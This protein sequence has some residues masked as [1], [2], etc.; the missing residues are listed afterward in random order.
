[1]LAAGGSAVDAAVAAG[2]VLCVALPDTCGLGGDVLA[3]VRAPDRTEAAYNGSG[4]APAAF[5]GM[6]PADG[7]GAAAVPGA[8][9]ALAEL[10]ERHGVLPWHRV[11][12]PASPFI[13]VTQGAFVAQLFQFSHI[14]QNRAGQQ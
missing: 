7:A 5:A 8:V 2:A 3:L 13:G 1:M 12:S 9:A 4:R 14:V 10:H 6:V 11:L